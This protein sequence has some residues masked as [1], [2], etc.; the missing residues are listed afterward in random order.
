MPREFTSASTRNLPLAMIPLSGPEISSRKELTL[1]GV[2]PFS[3]LDFP[4]VLSAVLFCQ[5]C[6]W[7]C[8]YCHNPHLRSFAPHQYRDGWDW[9][10]ARDLLM[11]R[12]G[13][14]EGVV[15]SGGEPTAQPALADAIKEVREMGYRVGL[16][17]SG[18]YPIKLI[19]L[20]P[21]VY[22]I[23]L[24]IKAPLDFRYDLIT[25]ISGSARPT[26]A[27]LEAIIASGIDYQ[28]RTTV[29]P[30]LLS[31]LDLREIEQQLT[32]I[33]AHTPVI[34]PFRAQGCLD[35]ELV[36]DATSLNTGVDSTQRGVS[37]PEPLH[38]YQ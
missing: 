28:I 17:T 18:S 10:R 35:S 33:G 21:L 20:L 9:P 1:S 7:L 37:L 5:G 30:K 31:H 6:P 32:S 23:G 24:D 4:G 15:F 29:H 27:S 34:Q 3:T 25:G 8:R 14:L 36:A 22:W 11:K 2:I 38:R 19:P 12:I 16:H 13:F 26:R